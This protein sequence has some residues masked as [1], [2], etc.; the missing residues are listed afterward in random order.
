MSPAI[1]NVASTKHTWQ[2]NLPDECE[3]GFFICPVK[4]ILTQEQIFQAFFPLCLTGDHSSN[5]PPFLG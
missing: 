1:L 4:C 3:D 5:K 2:V